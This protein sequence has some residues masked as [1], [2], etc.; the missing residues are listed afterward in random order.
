MCEAGPMSKNRIL[1]LFK[2]GVSLKQC[3]S[4][5]VEASEVVQLAPS[6]RLT[7]N[8]IAWQV[9]NKAQPPGWLDEVRTYFADIED[10]AN[11]SSKVLLCFEVADRTWALTYGGGRHLINHNHTEP[12]FG[13]M[14]TANSINPQE[15]LGAESRTSDQ[16]AR[17]ISSRMATGSRLQ[18]L[19][20][21]FDDELL[22]SLSGRP[23]HDTWFKR[24]AGADSLSVTCDIELTE[25]PELAKQSLTAF[26]S[27]TY[28]QGYSFLDNLTPV[29]K[30]D[31]R[32]EY[33]NSHLAN[34]VLDGEPHEFAVALPRL[35]DDHAIGT[36]H[37]IR[38]KTV[39]IE[40]TAKSVQEGLAAL[41]VRTS[42]DL[43]KCKIRVMDLDEVEALIGPRSLIAF[44]TLE[45]T[46]SGDT[47]VHIDNEWYQVSRDYVEQVNRAITEIETSEPPLPSLPKVTSTAKGKS[48]HMCEGCYN[49]TAAAELGFT[50]LDRHLIHHGGPNQKTEF[51]DI[52]D[53]ETGRLYHVKKRTSSATLSHLWAQGEVAVDLYEKD[54]KYHQKV[55]DTLPGIGL[56]NSPRDITLVYA[57]ACELDKPLSESLFFMAKANL[58][59]RLVTIRRIVNKVELIRILMTDEQTDDY[60]K[61]QKCTD[62]VDVGETANEAS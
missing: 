19:G 6:P 58:T 14:V 4:T 27:E 10:L 45:A 5:T 60:T 30:S 18:D 47:F 17:L 22:K 21:D 31:P 9:A 37:L 34:T 1:Y 61:C 2:Q 55:L 59:A 32:T 23:N 24:V 41:G 28:K 44:I 35:I 20:I 26:Q 29:T 52:W 25:L 8:H 12:R 42:E 56:P 7:F 57:V 13:L 33:L 51:G 54:S 11:V 50:C 49:A 40:L 62:R 53:Q 16:R 38:N 39:E 48:S 46:L 3:L 43:E 15:L 36:V